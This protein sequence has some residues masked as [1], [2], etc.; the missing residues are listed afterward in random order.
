MPTVKT[1]RAQQQTA[2]LPGPQRGRVP[3]TQL[4]TPILSA[5]PSAAA[6]GV[7]AGEN[8]RALGEYAFSQELHFQ[9][10]LRQKA[11][12]QQDRVAI[13][14][15]DR[16]L[17][18]WETRT[19]YDPQQGA[20]NVK[21][22]NAGGLPEVVSKDFE[23]TYGAIWQNLANDEQRLA[24]D[25][26]AQT[27][28]RDVHETVMR[29]VSRQLTDVEGAEQAAYLQN[30]REAA[31]ANALDPIRV[32]KEIQRQH[33]AIST[34]AQTHG[35]GPEW[36]QGEI[37]KADSQTHTDVLNRMLALGQ[38]LKAKTYYEAHHE[39]IL[40]T[41]LAAIDKDMKE[42]SLRGESQRQADQILTQFPTE[43]EAHDA[44]KAIPN[45]DVRDLTVQRVDAEWRLKKQRQDED[46]RA[47]VQQAKD[48]LDQHM[49][50]MENL[51]D[52]KRPV[53]ARDVVPP[54]IWNAL[55]HNNRQA[56]ESYARQYQKEGGIDTDY[57]TYYSLMRQA[58]EDP[59]AFLKH[60]LFGEYGH[61]LNPKVELKQ[62]QELQ[63]SIR[64]R[65]TT[66]AD[67]VLDGIRTNERIVN[68]TLRQMG[69]DPEKE[70]ARTDQLWNRVD[71]QVLELQRNTGK[72]ATNDDIQGIVDKLLIDV[73]TEKGW[74]WDTTKRIFE[75][76]I[77]DVP[78]ADRQQIERALHSVHR[79][80][81]DDAILNLYIQTQQRLQKK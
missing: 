6:F 17:S 80:V 66:E 72:K 38:D 55:P 69:I 42:G 16:Q 31:A 39:D 43:E 67:K 20:L 52:R 3:T 77:T 53:F 14:N 34:F 18:E 32:G 50:Q 10:Q 54:N 58:S 62:L 36:E 45:P 56:L 70:K 19:L 7:Q 71:K 41:S 30:S 12:T 49:Q 48:A 23:K 4:Q 47:M 27:R 76:T 29:H 13:L 61:K 37:A 44:A 81:T 63:N 21:G 26:L 73:T 65:N 9:D 33:N 15:A 79:Q 24:F 28:R 40:G 11:K 57:S 5:E 59:A 60:D 35:L 68:G 46:E 8:V 2:P 25:Q 22:K 78:A 1:Y 51:I 74:F 75:I 64:Q